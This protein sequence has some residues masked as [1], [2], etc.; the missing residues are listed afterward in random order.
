MTS[1]LD[2]KMIKI[3]LGIELRRLREDSGHTAAEAAEVVGGAGPK[4]SKIENGKQGIT[5]EE[6]E[7]L[8]NLYDAP[9]KRRK[10]L[11]G[12]AE[13]LPKRSRR[14]SAQ[15][16]AVPGWF[17]RFLALESDATAMKIFEVDIVTGL[18][19]TE[20]YARSTIEA[21]EPAA[22]PR[23]V[24]RQ[25]QTRLRRQSLLSKRNPVELQ[26]VLSEA[27]L[28]RVQG[29]P[30]IMSAQLE[31]LIASSER[32][33]V[34]LRVLPFEARDRIA[35]ASAATLLYLAGQ[36]LSVVYLEDVL[37]ATYL[38]EPEEYTGYSVVFERL[39]S[40]ALSPGE[41]RDFIDR[42]RK[43]YDQVTRQ[44]GCTCAHPGVICCNVA[45]GES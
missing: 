30:E 19:Q 42:V 44:K 35:V 36:R 31:S 23:L 17:E 6:V 33:N 9:A 37:G 22:D 4:I 34:E 10:Y 26:V 29:G 15:R 20:D 3:Q 12:L 11:V 40:A 38:W 1:S 43:Y 21:W 2:S 5:P 18:L 16:D 25:V 32:T 8:A 41:S 13:Q 24:D 27:A 7:K 45:Q 14:R 28:R 39:R